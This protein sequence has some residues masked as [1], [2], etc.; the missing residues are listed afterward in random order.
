MTPPP[1]HSEA[2]TDG[3]PSKQTLETGN[4]QRIIVSF[5]LERLN[6]SKNK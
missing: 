1:Q 3:L 4:L 5:K 2:T 6:S